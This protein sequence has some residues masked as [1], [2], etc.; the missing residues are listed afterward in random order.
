MID[1]GNTWSTKRKKERKK[2]FLLRSE[3]CVSFDIKR[4]TWLGLRVALAAEREIRKNYIELHI[5]THTSNFFHEISEWNF[6]L[7]IAYY[8]SIACLLCVDTTVYIRIT[9]RLITK[10]MSNILRKNKNFLPSTF[11]A[12]SFFFFFFSFIWLSTGARNIISLLNWQIFCFRIN[13]F[14][15]T[16]KHKRRRFFFTFI[17]LLPR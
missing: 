9:Q 12:C 14:H 8:V 10:L 1:S 2:F 6:S 5:Y 13:I 7:C 4:R 16:R 11:Q 15:T 17:R 3:L